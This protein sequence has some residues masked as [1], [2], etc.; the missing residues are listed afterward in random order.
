MLFKSA[1]LESWKLVE[2]A[3]FVRHATKYIDYLMLHSAIAALYEMQV[4]ELYF[5]R[6]PKTEWYHSFE[7]RCRRNSKPYFMVKHQTNSRTANTTSHSIVSRY[8]Y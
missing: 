8:L 1:I 3:H 4:M 6:V 2:Q 7:T 5:F